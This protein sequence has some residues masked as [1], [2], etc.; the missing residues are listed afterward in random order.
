M[1]LTRKNRNTRGKTY[2]GTTLSTTN[3]TWT[4][5]KSKLGLRRESPAT[6]LLNHGTS[7]KT[8]AIRIY[9]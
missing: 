6:N 9:N 3:L 5:L 4:N 1:I 2:P 7:L 8:K